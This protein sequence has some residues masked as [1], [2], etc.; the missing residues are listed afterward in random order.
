MLAAAKADFEPHLAR[1]KPERR[2]P[3]GERRDADLQPRQEF[4]DE[5]RVMGAEGLASAAAVQSPTPRRDIAG[6]VGCAVR[7]ERR[8]GVF[9][10]YARP[11]N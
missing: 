6:G 7:F 10:D 9:R 4:G 1:R 8:R 2:I 3:G 5:P 11:R